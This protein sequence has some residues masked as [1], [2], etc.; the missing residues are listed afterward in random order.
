[1]AEL[2]T[3]HKRANRLHLAIFDMEGA[4]RYLE[5]YI[6][7]NKLTEG[8]PPGLGDTVPAPK[9]CWSSTTTNSAAARRASGGKQILHSDSKSENS[10]SNCAITTANPDIKSALRPVPLV[11]FPATYSQITQIG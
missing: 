2:S 11:G 6:K 10:Y 7:L 4:R 1:M 9:R 8:L 5:A 3:E